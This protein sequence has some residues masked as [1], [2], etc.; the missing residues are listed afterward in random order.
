[1]RLKTAVFLRHL[2]NQIQAPLLSLEVRSESLRPVILDKVHR[3]ANISF[4]PSELNAFPTRKRVF[5]IKFINFSI[6]I[7]SLR[8][9]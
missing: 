6:N 3:H 1:M 2:S 9:P 5:Y 4:V 8:C 7:E